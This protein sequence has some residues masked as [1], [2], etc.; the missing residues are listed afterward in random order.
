MP[1]DR[2][3]VVTDH[4]YAAQITELGTAA[5]DPEASHSQAHDI[6]ADLLDEHYPLTADAWRKA[7]GSWW[8]A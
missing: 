6:I 8:Y 1:T 4:D 2:D 3:G 5:G 7:S